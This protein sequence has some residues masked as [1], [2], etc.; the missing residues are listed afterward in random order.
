MNSG[1][2]P[3]TAATSSNPYPYYEQLRTKL[4][5]HFDD[6]LNLW[7]A[8]SAS[9][10][11]LILANPSCRV[12][13]AD[14]PVPKPILGSAAA[15]VFGNLARTNDGPKHQAL[16]GM[17]SS[18]L[19][20][21]SPSQVRKKAQYWSA[22]L[23]QELSPHRI[24]PGLTSFC[25]QIP[26]CV[27]A[28]LIGIDRA[29][30]K[31]VIGWIDAYCRCVAAGASQEQIQSGRE[32]AASLLESIRACMARAEGE[33]TRNGLIG[34]MLEAAKV[35]ASITFDQ[36]AA[37]CIG[38]LTQGYEGN[39]GLIS[40]TLLLLAQRHDL[41]KRVTSDL[42]QTEM[43]VRESGRFDPATQNT[44]RFVVDDVEIAGKEVRAGQAILLIVAAA[45]RDPAAN[46]HPDSF[47][48][49]RENAAIFSFSA[50]RHACPGQ[51][52]AETIAAT[53]TAHLLERNIDL[54]RVVQPTKYRNSIN[55]RV[56]ELVMA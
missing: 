33:Q 28:D 50:S 3:L 35:D 46:P 19:E 7:I 16:K 41:Q 45:N 10:I 40:N 17:V 36:I 4:G 30:F 55:T 56:A 21:L 20:T 23:Y 18:V 14:E 34:A 54:S 13:P 24:G 51:I 47:D 8:T 6:D 32:A 2:S 44:R 27:M 31:E 22:R 15:T 26:M 48:I 1:I 39:A 53:A 29:Q 38:L 9:D 5:L 25:Y 52:A 12:R 11:S 49:E 42:S 37:N 43:L